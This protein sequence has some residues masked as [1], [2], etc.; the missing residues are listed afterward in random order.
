MC[1]RLRA[2]DQRRSREFCFSMC[3]HANDCTNT[4]IPI[5]RRSN[6]DRLESVPLRPFSGRAPRPARYRGTLIIVSVALMVLS[7]VYGVFPTWASE[8]TSEPKRPAYQIRRFDEDWSGLKGVNRSQTGD[9]WDLIKFIPVTEDYNVWLSLGGQVR[10]R[11]EYYHQYFFGASA[12]EKSDGYLLSRFRLSADLHITPY[13]RLFAEGKSSLSTE[14]E[15]LGGRSNSYVDTI[16]LQ[17]GFGEFMLPLGKETSV[18]LR[19]GRQELLFGAQRLVG[20]SDWGGNV[21]RTF[22]GGL[23]VIR[24]RDWSITPFWAE[25]VP[26]KKHDFNESTSRNKLYGV[27]STGGLHI[28]PLN[29][30]LYWLDVNNKTAAFNGTSG[31]ERRHTLGGRIWGKIGTTGLDFEVEGAGQ[32]GEI[33]HQDIAAWMLTAILGYSPPI[34]NLSPRVYAEFDYASGD[35]HPGGDVGTFNQLYPTGHSFLGYIDY[36]GRQN[37]ISPSAGLSLNPIRGLSISLQEYFFWRESD[38]DALYNKSGGVIRPG[39][40]T[41]ARYVGS[42]TDLYITYNLDRHILVYGGYSHFFPGDFID[43]TGPDKD[44]DFLYTAIQ[45]TF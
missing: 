14:R 42:E 34:A 21:R 35:S 9:F 6:V 36:I 31:R 32:F 16:D 37:I 22:D 2:D 39:T 38:R 18:M 43:K 12:P 8:S 25:F 40:T 27:Y 41:T 44:S 28:L 17:N 3:A 24:Y 29:V 15:L 19:G 13:F 45:Y 1:N 10:E 11:Y 20:P 7:F 30:D 4:I 5:M 33:G 26:V 23:G